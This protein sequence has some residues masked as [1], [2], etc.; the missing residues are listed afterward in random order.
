MVKAVTEKPTNLLVLYPLGAEGLP[1][2]RRGVAAPGSKPFGAD[3]DP[4][5]RYILSEGNVGP[6]RMAVPDG[7]S[8][9]SATPTGTGVSLITDS[10]PT[11]ETAACWVQITPDGRFAYTTNTGSGSTTGF[12]LRHRDA[13]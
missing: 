5:G 10:S 9:S 12:H 1:G 3:F 8:A 7:S 4:A 6:R 11:T 13:H 2:A